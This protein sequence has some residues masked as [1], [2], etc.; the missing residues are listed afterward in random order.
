MINV[1]SLP[2]YGNINLKKK[3]I[4]NKNNVKCSIKINT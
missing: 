2:G 3:D 4:V 1:K